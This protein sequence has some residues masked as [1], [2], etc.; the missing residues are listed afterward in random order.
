MM[1]GIIGDMGV[2]QARKRTYYLLDATS[3]WDSTT[4]HVFT[5]PTGHRWKVLSICV[6]NDAN[7]TTN[8]Y[9]EDSTAVVKGLLSTQAANT[10][11]TQF[12][13]YVASVTVIGIQE[14]L[15]DAGERLHI[16]C[17]APQGAGAYIYLDVLEVYYA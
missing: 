11:R 3:T 9:W 6:K 5:V 7:A 2:P 15:M 12:P 4:E 14:V 8:I 13:C 17:G 10:A 1:A 16:V